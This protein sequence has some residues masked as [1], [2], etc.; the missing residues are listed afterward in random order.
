MARWTLLL[1]AGLLI[2]AASPLS[3]ELLIEYQDDVYLRDHETVRYAIDLDYGTGT[4]ASIEVLVRG[5]NAPPRV[6]ILDDNHHELKDARDTDG[7]W[8][9]NPSANA[10][11]PIVRYYVEVDSAIP[12]HDGD[13]EVT[14]FVDAPNGNNADAV[15]FFDK[16][17]FDHESG[18]ASDHYDCTAHSG[19]GSWPLAMIG[20]VAGGALWFRRCRRTPALNRGTPGND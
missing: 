6:R 19:A 12:S 20:L 4:D 11:A 7:D 9:V 17:Y 15:V 10:H 5:F 2:S 8:T 18:D 1:L 3:A 13:F 14:I 16:Y